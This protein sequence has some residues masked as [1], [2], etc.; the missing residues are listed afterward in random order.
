ML[1]SRNIRALI[2]LD[3]DLPNVLADHESLHRVFLNLGE[4]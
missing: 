3:D 2:T 1:E 4:Q